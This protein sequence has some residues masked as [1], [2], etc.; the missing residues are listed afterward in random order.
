MP[1][2]RQLAAIMFT[3]I[4]GYTAIM[5]TDEQKA[6]AVIKHYN[7]TLE[8]L[9]SQFNGQV[10]NYYGDG[11]LCIFPNATDAATCSLDLQKEL[12]NDPGVPLRIGLHIGEVF[13]ENEKALGDGVNVASRVQSLGQENTILVS[14][15]FYD[16]IK[17]NS[18]FST[19]SLGQFDFKNV[20][21]P[22]EVFAFSNEGLFVPLRSKMEGKLKKKSGKKRIITAASLIILFCAVVFFIYK[23]FFTEKAESGSNDQ[24]IAVLPFEDMSPAKDQEYFS[25]GMS[26]ELLNLLSK[27]QGLK[28]ISR[29]S[30]FSFKGKNLDVRKI[31]ENLGVANILEGSIRK[32]GNTIRI[33]AQLIEVSNGTHLWSETYDRQMQDVFAI[34]DEI[35]KMIVD[36]L[37]IKLSGKQTN[38]LAGSFTKNPEAHEDYLKGRYHWNTRTDEGL[39]KAIGYF[40]DAIKKDSNY[41]AAYSGLADTYLT[42]YDYG[43]MSIDE[44]TLKAKD[45]AQRAL[46]INENLAEAHN[47]LAHINL[48]EWKWESAEEGFRKAITLDPGYILAHHWYALCLT[49]VGKTNEAVTQMEKARELDPLSTRINADLGMAYLSAGRYDEAI[50]QEQ[51]TM[52]LNPKSAGARWIRGMAYQQKKMFEQAIKDYRDA[53]ELSPGNSNILA[54]LG[55]VYASSGNTSAAHKILDSLY[56]K[57]KKEPVSPF[58]FAL[59]YAG[60]NDK[61]NAL[62]WLEKSYEEKSGSVRYLKMEPRLQNLRKEPRYI[63]LMKKIGLEK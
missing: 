61:E 47:S 1:Q 14:A 24:S 34:Q 63:A 18:S 17:N 6:V 53:L 62:K 38:L 20:E 27:I 46:M 55:H 43:L 54:A 35:S 19:V 15:E 9:V 52:E 39:K 51:K 8:K 7:F 16:K 13:F 31:G 29:T 40:E 25:D 30:S 50:A 57:N 21:K 2:S 12:K 41:A 49:A 5:Q 26:E 60:L 56:V 44:S 33:T 36:I 42:L 58:F 10:L 28:V 48:H 4:V 11:S 45:A 59:V 3:D 22:L 32:S 23:T 37:K